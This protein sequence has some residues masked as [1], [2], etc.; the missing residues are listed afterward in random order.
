MDEAKLNEYRQKWKAKIQLL[1]NHSNKLNENEIRWVNICKKAM[2]DKNE[3]SRKL[4]K[5]LNDIYE[6]FLS[7]I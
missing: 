5:T 3:L 7:N 6:R 1:L 4:S 2:C